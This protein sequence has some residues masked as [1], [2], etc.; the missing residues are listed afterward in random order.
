MLNFD[1][2]LLAKSVFF[3]DSFSCCYYDGYVLR[4][5]LI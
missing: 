2:I 4:I 5:D 3:L 1:E